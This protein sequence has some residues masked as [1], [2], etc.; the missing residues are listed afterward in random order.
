M[1]F[2]VVCGIDLWWYVVV[3]CGCGGYR[4]WFVGLVVMVVMMVACVGGSALVVCD[5]GCLW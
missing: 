2:G 5:C 4:C 1:V 3:V